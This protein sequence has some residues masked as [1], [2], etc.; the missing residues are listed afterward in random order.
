MRRCAIPNRHYLC[1][2]KEN[3]QHS[4]Y[5]GTRVVS[6]NVDDHEVRYASPDHL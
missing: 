3:L 5:C 6:R 4:A 2:L 1:T